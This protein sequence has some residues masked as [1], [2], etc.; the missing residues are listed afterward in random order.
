MAPAGGPDLQDV[1]VL[2]VEDNDD[3][4]LSIAML[5]E[6]PGRALTACAN[7]EEA[8]ALCAAN[9]YDIVITD[10]SLPGISGTDLAKQLLAKQPDRWVVLCSGYE[11]GEWVR[12]FG[13]HVRA[14]RKPFEP[15]ELEQLM[16]EISAAV[17]S[18]G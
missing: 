13:P 17:R 12:Q 3:L 7:G 1:T 11:F 14:L 16:D 4:R 5:M 18:R 15:E 10:V 6:Q 2:Y 9:E 8:L